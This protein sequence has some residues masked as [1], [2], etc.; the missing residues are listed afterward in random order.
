MSQSARGGFIRTAERVLASVEWLGALIVA[1]LMSAIMTIV[2][3]DVFFR[4]LLNRP[5]S[6]AYDLI[7]LYLMAG[8][9]FLTLSG[10]YAARAHVGLDIVY[11]MMPPR[12]RNVADLVTNLSGVAL[13]SVIAKIGFDRFLAAFIAGDVIAGTIPW[14]TWPSYLLIPLGA[15]M[16]TLRMLIHA[17][18]DVVSLA[19]GTKFDFNPVESTDRHTPGTVA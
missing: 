17:A 3:S 7:S 14:P 9:F 19:T 1:F 18:A 2:V 16:L 6:W 12:L 11:Q 15:G 13:F 5:F 4:Y 8:L 10:A